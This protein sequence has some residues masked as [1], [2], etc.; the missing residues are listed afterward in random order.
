MPPKTKTK[1]GGLSVKKSDAIS[2]NRARSLRR[3]L[4]LKP[5]ADDLMIELHAVDP[6]TVLAFVIDK[7]APAGLAVRASRVG[8]RRGD[9]R[10]WLSCLR[11]GRPIKQP[12]LIRAG[13]RDAILTVL[14]DCRDQVRGPDTRT[15]AYDTLCSLADA[16]IS[17]AFGQREIAELDAD[18][19]TVKVWN[20]PHPGD[21][22]WLIDGIEPE[23]RG[24]GYYGG[25]AVGKTYLAVA[26][27]V[28]V[29]SGRPF[30]KR[31]VRPGPVLCLDWE[32][33]EEEFTRRAYEIALGM[34]MSAPPKGLY[35]K[36]MRHPLLECT[37]LIRAM[38]DKLL[39]TS[40]SVDS[41][42]V[43]GADEAAPARAAIQFLDSLA[44][45]YVVFDHQA[46]TQHMDNYSEKLP[47]G[48]MFKEAGLRS[49]WQLDPA[50]VNP[51]NGLNLILRDQKSSFSG[52]RSEI[53]VGLRF[54][55]SAVRVLRLR[56]GKTPG[57]VEK[58]SA[59]Q[60]II[61][62]L[63]KLGE[64]TPEAIA[65]ETGLAK[66]TVTSQLSRLKSARKVKS[67]PGDRPNMPHSYALTTPPTTQPRRVVPK[68]TTTRQRGKGNNADNADNAEPNNAEKEQ[69]D[70]AND[71]RTAATKRKRKRK[72]GDNDA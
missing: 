21:R 30:L 17:G 4:K 6:H 14:L 69:L 53:A 25:T 29:A 12:R 44:V 11:G 40:V 47:Y 41:F 37:D 10:V 48:T 43:A 3:N 54:D 51:P 46:R 65:E 9:D 60:R 28:C 26:R 42:S 59:D 32:L 72:G 45:S 7:D 68:G 62:A 16:A 64:T 63:E 35:Y 49:V 56:M 18:E 70:L 55:D 19:E 67:T 2:P 27:A 52:V 71:S 23:E 57:L 58:L 22:R 34:G 8:E 15:V 1:S 13:D 66:S 50:S 20:Q 36:R 33:D 24:T 31:R 61:I 38:V 5:R 39:I